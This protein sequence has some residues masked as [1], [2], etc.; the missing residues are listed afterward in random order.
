LYVR[1]YWKS[2]FRVPTFNELYYYH[3]G[4]TTLKPENTSQWNLGLTGEVPGSKVSVRFSA[5]G[6]VSRVSDKIVAI[7][8][9]MFVWRTMNVARVD[10]T[11]ADLT[12]GVTGHLDRRQQLELT[13]NY[14][15][16]RVRNHTRRESPNYGNQIAYVPE[17][18]FSTSLTW[19]N[20]WVGVAFTADG[21]SNRWATNEHA[22]ARASQGFVELG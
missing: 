15:L 8:F 2:I 3:I 13:G 12:L 21:M 6:Y 5:D 22:E 10:V 1:A 20:P 18:T 7:P 4:S 16:Q 14:S 17:H 11:G 9:N 19:L